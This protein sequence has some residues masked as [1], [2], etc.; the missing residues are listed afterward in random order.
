[1]RDR[2]LSC[3]QAPWMVMEVAYIYI[4]YLE[5]Y[6]VN[7]SN[8]NGFLTSKPTSCKSNPNK[9]FAPGGNIK[10]VGE[11]HQVNLSCPNLLEDK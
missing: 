9:I 8:F 3:S 10:T 2:R 7:R 4:R 11:Y 1:M 6:T 5:L